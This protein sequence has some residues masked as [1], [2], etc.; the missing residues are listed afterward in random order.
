VFKDIGP[1]FDFG[2]IASF[3]LRWRLQSNASSTAEGAF[4][5]DIAMR[6]KRPTY[7]SGFG[8]TVRSGTSMASPHVAGA[9]AL[10]FAKSVGAAPVGVKN[11]I[12]NGV[13][14]KASLNGLVAT[15]GRLNLV[16]MLTRLACCHVRP[17]AASSV[18]VPL[19]PAYN[20]CTSPNRVHGPPNLPGGGNPTDGSC[21]PP[22]QRSALVTVGTNDANGAGTNSVGRL[23]FQT[24]AGDPGTPGDQA[25]VAVSVNITDVRAKT[26]G[27]PD[28]PGQ[29]LARFP[30]RWTDRRN[31]P[32]QTEAATLQDGVVQHA[33]P[34]ATTAST[35]IGSTCSLSSTVEAIVGDSGIAV[36]G[37]RTVWE[38]G[39]AELR[40]GGPDGNVFTEPNTVFAVQGVFVP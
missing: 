2:E 32:A 22:A 36:E 10:A 7:P 39:Q 3:Y 12:L 34:C 18:S 24:I 33:V 27:V 4:V 38:F 13:D 20:Q 14:K 9:A 21:A 37:A 35:T 29:L 15:G 28:Y 31:G 25:D 8:Y 26:A 23:K 16:G 6:C 17:Q 1:P 30:N 19:V 11:A 5:D 40:D